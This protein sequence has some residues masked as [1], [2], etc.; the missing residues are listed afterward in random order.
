MTFLPLVMT[1]PPHRGASCEVKEFRL[2]SRSESGSASASGVETKSVSVNRIPPEDSS[3]GCLRQTE[4][5]HLVLKPRLTGQ[6]HVQLPYKPEAPA[7][8]HFATHSLA[9]G[10]L[11]L[12][13]CRHHNLKRNGVLI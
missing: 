2:G 13:I 10:I 8:E 4:D 11:K 3:R 6:R 5:G 1:P 12:R 7:S 9:G